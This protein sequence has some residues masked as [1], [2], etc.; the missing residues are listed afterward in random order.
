MPGKLD[1]LSIIVPESRELDLFAGLLEAEGATAIR[2]PLVQIAGLDDA[3]AL[4]AWID[5]L[6]AGE[7][8][9]LILLTG[10]GLRRIVSRAERLGRRPAAVD[11]LKRVRT[12][13]RGPKPA[14]ALRELGLSPGISA[15]TPTSE[16]VVDAVAG[17]DLQGRKIGVQLYPGKT[18]GWIVN[19][20]K[21][22]GALVS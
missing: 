10:E 16:G 12:I 11:A 21:A 22:K 13:I 15:A 6:I 20:L 2:C 19:A 4:D 7:F 9:D 18:A 3:S 14:R 1:G 17:Q 5:L 8:E